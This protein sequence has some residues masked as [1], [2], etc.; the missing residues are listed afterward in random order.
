MMMRSVTCRKQLGISVQEL[1]LVMAI[2]AMAIVSI[3][4]VNGFFQVLKV[5]SAVNE[6]SATL[7]LARQL[8]VRSRASHVFIP[9]AAD[10][11]WQLRNLETGKIV[12]HGQLPSGVTH[13]VLSAFQ[14]DKNGQCLNPTIFDGDLP[15]SQYLQLE[16]DLLSGRK[17]RY[18]LTLSPISQVTTTA[19][20]FE[21]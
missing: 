11:T 19:K 1:L 16:A 7:N 10:N 12:R 8:A 17:V 2:L 14:F 13:S 15:T 18:T 9:M 21:S 3:P 5:R 6:I 4:N 20:H